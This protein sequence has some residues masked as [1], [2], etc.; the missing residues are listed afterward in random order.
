MEEP[1]VAPSTYHQKG[2][3]EVMAEAFVIPARS[4]LLIARLQQILVD[5]EAMEHSPRLWMAVEEDLVGVA[6]Q[7]GVQA[8]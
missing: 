1:V 7:F 6:E 3:A 4:L 2:V 5:M 8:A